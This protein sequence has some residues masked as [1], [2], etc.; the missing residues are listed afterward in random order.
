MKTSY[1]RLLVLPVL[2]VS[3]SA[4]TQL[5]LQPSFGLGGQSVNY[6]YEGATVEG[7]SGVNL[8]AD[9]YYYLNEDIA[10]GAGVRFSGYKAT[11][12]LSNSSVQESGVDIDGDAY[13]LNRVSN[14][15]AESHSVSAIEIPLLARYQKWVSGSF[16][17]F[18]STGPVFVIPGSVK[19]EFD[20]GVY[21]TSGYYEKWNLTID[22]ANEYGFIS[23]DL[24]NYTPELKS[25]A[26]MSWTV[27]LGTEYFINKRLNLMVVAFYQPGLSG[28][29]DSSGDQEVADPLVFNGSMAGADQVKINKMGI[30][31]G[32]NF[33]LTPPEK[34]SIR[35]IR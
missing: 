7:A 20:S 16:I 9:L 25:K 22:D 24:S 10:L 3:I 5:R 14:N 23:Q 1:K 15:I 26:S 31:V 35:S 21:A 4:M 28:V 18:G 8:G 30:R 19:T 32:I 17:V 11:T 12:S 6:D 34:S 27:E 29:I 2:L 13:Q 33:N